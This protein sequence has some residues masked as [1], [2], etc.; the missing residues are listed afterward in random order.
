MVKIYTSFKL[1]NLPMKIQTKMLTVKSLSYLYTPSTSKIEPP[2]VTKNAELPIEKLTWEDFERLCLR[3]VQTQFSIDDCEIYGI[4]GQKQYGIDIFAR[5]NKN[6]YSCYQC[7]K[8]K[9]LKPKTLE[10]AVL[11][12]K[13]G[14]WFGKSDKFVFCTS[15]ALN[16]T[17]L[18]E[19]FEKLKDDLI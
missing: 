9:E 10:D 13:K 1:Y 11:E 12:F 14:T 5:N 17:Q 3:L 2:L 16:T 15:L 18:Q 19:K 6:R 4:Q 8:Y 7:K